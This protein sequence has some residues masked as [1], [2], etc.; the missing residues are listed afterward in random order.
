[1]QTISHICVIKIEGNDAIS[2]LNNLSTN[3]LQK[4]EFGTQSSIYSC[5][6]T[7]NGRFMF[8]F[9]LLQNHG[10]NSDENYIL[11]H[12]DF[13]NSFIKYLSMYK[14]SADISLFATDFTVLHSFF[15]I[16]DYFPDSRNKNLGFY[17]IS[18]TAN[19]STNI[20]STDISTQFH[21]NRIKLKIADGFYDLTQRESIILEY[22]ID[23]PTAICY[24]K[25]CYLG[26]ELISRTKHTGIIRKEIHYFPSNLELP[27]HEKITQNGVEIGKVLGSIYEEKPNIYH[28]LALIHKE[29][30][31]FE[32]IFETASFQHKFDLQYS[33]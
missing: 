5:I 1:M 14:L 24:K 20:D 11:V 29:K 18:N 26:Q 21:I 8:D 15:E 30:T 13:T 19:Q 10:K 9:H 3:L 28:N 2:F 23:E 27:K 22:G 33:Q 31:N 16:N 7:P 25:G 6:L 4:A 12:K 32:D 17:K